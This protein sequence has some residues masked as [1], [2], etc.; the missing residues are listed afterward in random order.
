MSQV[1][2]NQVAPHSGLL[3]YRTTLVPTSGKSRQ[4]CAGAVRFSSETQSLRSLSKGWFDD[5]VAIFHSL[6]A[7]RRRP[8]YGRLGRLAG[9]DGAARA[10]R[11]GLPRPGRAPAVGGLGAL[12]VA[13]DAGL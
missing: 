8:R 11:A 9:A 5:P 6:G 3:P 4:P 1:A 7:W 2:M 12:S 13:C 10:R